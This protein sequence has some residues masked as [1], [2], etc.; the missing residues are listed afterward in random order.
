M[1][2]TQ[3]QKCV[4]DHTVRIED[5]QISRAL[6]TQAE[7][8]LK[9]ANKEIAQVPNKAQAEALAFQVSLRKEQVHSRLL[10]R[11]AEQ[12]TKENNGL[13]GICAHLISKTEKM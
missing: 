7:E 13:A 4:E 9:L 10:E 8:K 12:K 5:G 3:T 11:T 6:K 2:I 1:L